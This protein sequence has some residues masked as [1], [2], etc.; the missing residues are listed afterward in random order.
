M[1]GF[2]AGAAFALLLLWC[3]SADAQSASTVDTESIVALGAGERAPFSGMLWPTSRSL[4]T[5]QRIEM[6][7]ERLHLD[8]AACEATGVLRVQLAEETRRIESERY[9][10]DRAALLVALRE[11]E[12]R[13]VRSWYEN[14]T[15]WLG[16]GIVLTVV[17]V[18]AIAYAL[19]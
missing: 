7:E 12:K 14:P 10:T 5:V 15:L 17:V 13:A 8:V 16:T 3:A 9:V 19:H 2:C 1:R 18:V 11:A 4:R 6:L